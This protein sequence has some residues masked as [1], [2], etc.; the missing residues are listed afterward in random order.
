MLWMLAARGGRGIFWLIY[1]LFRGIS[2]GEP[3][4]IAIAVA[5]LVCIVGWTMYKKFSPQ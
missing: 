1:L 5:I 2:R 4:S 3:T